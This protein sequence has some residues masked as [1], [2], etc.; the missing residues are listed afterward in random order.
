[1]N[2]R[3]GESNECFEGSRQEMGTL[4]EMDEVGRIGATSK[5][6]YLVET[7]EGVT[8]ELYLLTPKAIGLH[9]E[10][11]GILQEHTTPQIQEPHSVGER[12]QPRVAYSPSTFCKFVNLYN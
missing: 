11:E 3:F 6:D 2:E 7:L 9:Y 5:E 10:V 8:R 1:L 4:G 12:T